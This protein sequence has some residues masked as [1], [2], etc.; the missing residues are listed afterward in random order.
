MIDIGSYHADDRAFRALTGW[1][2]RVTLADGLRRTLDW[3]RP[4]LPA[5]LSDEI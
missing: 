4:R 2:P 1:A 5:Y 3:F